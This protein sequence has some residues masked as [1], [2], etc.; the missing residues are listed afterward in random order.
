MASDILDVSEEVNFLDQ[1]IAINLSLNDLVDDR[2]SFLSGIAGI[3]AVVALTQLFSTTGLVRIGFLVVTLTGLVTIILSVGVIRPTSLKLKRVNL[4]YYG[5]ISHYEEKKYYSMIKDTLESKEDMIKEY[6]KEIY[7]LS[8]ELKA[9]F[10]L[11]RRTGDILVTGLI[12]G[13]ILILFSFLIP[14]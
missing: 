5:G 11:I 4:M 9:R 10:K 6:V 2:A 8:E 13:F 7:D 12:A 1:I 3:I 14:L